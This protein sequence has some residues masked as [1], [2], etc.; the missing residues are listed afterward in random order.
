MHNPIRVENFGRSVGEVAEGGRTQ[1][2][3]FVYGSFRQ[4]VSKQRIRNNF[5]AGRRLT[6]GELAVVHPKATLNGG[7]TWT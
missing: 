7:S 5:K 1:F 3:L 2:F 6:A 4:K